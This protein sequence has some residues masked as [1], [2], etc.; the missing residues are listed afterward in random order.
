MNLVASPT[1]GSRILDVIVTNM[2]TSYDKAVVLPPLQPDRPGHGAPGDHS[3][4][5]ARPNLNSALRTGFSR[6]E[7]RTRRIVTASGLALMCLYLATMDWSAM[8]AA[9][10]AD[11]NVEGTPRSGL[12]ADKYPSVGRSGIA[13]VTLGFSSCHTLSDQPRTASH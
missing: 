2:H 8:H 13:A 1:R 3:V 9:V 10:G 4:P 5:V 6:T 7:T 12:A 11:A